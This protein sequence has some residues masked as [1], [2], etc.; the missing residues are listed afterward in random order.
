MI[1]YLIYIKKDWTEHEKWFSI[2]LSLDGDDGLIVVAISCDPKMIGDMH[3]GTKTS[4]YF[5]LCIYAIGNGKKHMFPNSK[6]HLKH[7]D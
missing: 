2:T 5:L 4:I 6:G 3:F 7:F 1:S